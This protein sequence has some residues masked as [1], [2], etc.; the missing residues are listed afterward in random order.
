MR[1][2]KLHVEAG[3]FLQTAV[4][5]LLFPFPWV[6]AMIIAG[7]AHEVGHLIALKAMN[8]TIYGLRLRAGGAY[9]ETSQI[10][11]K[12]EAIASLS[13]PILGISLLASSRWA[14]RVALCGAIHG[15]YNLIPI[16]PYDGGRAVTAALRAILPVHTVSTVCRIIKW[17]F[18]ITVII[19]SLLL[20]LIMRMGVAILLPG[21]I[22]LIK[23]F[24]PDNPS[25]DN[26]SL[27][28]KLA[29]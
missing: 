6:I 8:I 12:E 2:H 19:F 27:R 21:L 25:L 10:A 16:Y 7:A 22:L 4:L 29:L 11:L 14:P 20:F 13:G 17:M 26:F 24:A 18:C 28:D 1:F 5:L 9:V 15:L 23:A 3:F